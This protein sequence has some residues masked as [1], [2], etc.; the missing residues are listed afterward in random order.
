M[1]TTEYLFGEHRAVF[2]PE[3]TMVATLRVNA[4]RVLMQELA[5]QK[6]HSTGPALDALAVRYIAAEKARNFWLDILNEE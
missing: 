2:E 3:L 5:H 6:G 4:A 1:K